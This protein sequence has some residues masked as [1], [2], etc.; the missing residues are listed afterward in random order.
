MLCVAFQ[1]EGGHL[2]VSP[3]RGRG[4]RLIGFLRLVPAA[5][6]CDGWARRLGG[7]SRREFLIQRT[8]R[9][10]TCKSGPTRSESEGQNADSKPEAKGFC[11]CSIHQS[12]AARPSLEVTAPP[13]A[14]ASANSTTSTPT[15]PYHY[16]PIGPYRRGDWDCP[17]RRYILVLV[18]D[19]ERLRV[20]C[21]CAP[22]TH[23]AVL[24]WGVLRCQA[25]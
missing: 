8:S 22:R 9:Q 4:L 20:S 25:R 7:T 12:C 23:H 24:S 10:A 2:P 14:L 11:G 1:P 21:R 17:R 13:V 6:A 15:A 19:S 3:V 5:A 18:K 16:P